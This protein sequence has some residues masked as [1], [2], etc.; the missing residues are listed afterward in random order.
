MKMRENRIKTKVYYWLLRSV[1]DRNDGNPPTQR[2][3]R[4]KNYILVNTTDSNAR[5]IVPYENRPSSVDISGERIDRDGS[6]LVFFSVFQWE[7]LIEN[8]VRKFES[9]VLNR[10]SVDAILFKPA[11]LPRLDSPLFRAL[12]PIPYTTLWGY[13]RGK[14]REASRPEPKSI[15]KGKINTMTAGARLRD[16]RDFFEPS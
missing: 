5:S 8:S 12:H 13:T 9:R 7:V 14:S 4:F 16:W 11:S 15:R 3:N 6:M 1:D 2:W 10:I